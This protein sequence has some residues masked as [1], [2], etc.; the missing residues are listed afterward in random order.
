VCSNSN[1]AL[2]HRKPSVCVC[3]CVCVCLPLRVMF[4]RRA[5]CTQPT[6]SHSTRFDVVAVVLLWMQVS[7]DIRSCRWVFP[8]VSK[9]T[10]YRLSWSQHIRSR[11]ES[12]NRKRSSRCNVDAG[13]C[14]GA[15]SYLHDSVC[16]W[17]KA[18]VTLCLQC[19]PFNKKY[20]IPHLRVC[21]WWLWRL[22]VTCE[23]CS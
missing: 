4:L 16:L 10:A 20:F 13:E 11:R 3:V 22:Q 12:V 7:Q 2:W 14:F 1:S 15:S 8:D 23:S 17:H 6:F 19:S 9:G 21:R 5:H 18:A